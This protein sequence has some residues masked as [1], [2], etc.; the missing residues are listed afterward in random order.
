MLSVVAVAVRHKDHRRLV[1]LVAADELRRPA[2]RAIDPATV[3]PGYVALWRLH[4]FT[5][6][7][8]PANTGICRGMLTL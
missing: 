4:A 7:I 5:A 1:R 6:A 2:H 8:A 3:V